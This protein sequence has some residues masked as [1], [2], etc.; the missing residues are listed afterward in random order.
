MTDAQNA[1]S[2]N[3]EMPIS[4]NVSL[5]IFDKMC[6]TRYFEEQVYLNVK[7]GNITVPVYLSK[8]QESIA[9][10][11]SAVI[12]NYLIFTQHRCHGTYLAFGGDPEKLR[13]EL[14]GLPSGC[15][16]GRAGSNCLQIH[17]NGIDMFG[18]HGLVGENVPIAVGAAYGGEK[19]VVCFLGDGAAEEDYVLS[20]F[21]FASTHKLPILFIVEDNDLSILTTKSVRRSWHTKDV[22]SALGIN[23]VDITD[24]PHVIYNHTKKL[25]IK[26]P[27]LINCNTCRLSWHTGAGQD[28]DAMKWDRFTETKKYLIDNNMKNEMIRI[29]NYNI[30]LM[31]NIWNKKN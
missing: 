1:R 9:S 14:L 6:R 7:N 15:S 10:A 26:L 16:G 30:E 22:A 19:N 20:A 13:D 28:S 29:E 2:A 23:S 18:H 3:K 27:A 31:K 24:D 12:N 4:N 8:G 21:G 25:I 17:E 5:E 11:V